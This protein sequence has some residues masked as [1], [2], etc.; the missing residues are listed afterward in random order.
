MIHDQFKFQ[1]KRIKKKYL[2]MKIKILVIKQ[3]FLGK[4]IQNDYSNL[5]KSLFFKKKLN[6]IKIPNK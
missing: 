2:L 6:C 1:I 4:I 3:K 5:T